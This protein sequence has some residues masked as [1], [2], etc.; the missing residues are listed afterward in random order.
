MS[1]SSDDPID[2]LVGKRVRDRR[3]KLGICQ[4]R[5]GETLGISVDQIEK[6]ETSQE[7][8]GAGMLFRIA[9]ALD[10]PVNFFFDSEQAAIAS[11]VEELDFRPTTADLPDC[12]ALNRAFCAIGDPEIRQRII[13]LVASLKDKAA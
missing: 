12:I 5:F 3:L 13:D 11:E 8:I 6:C 10:V 9:E 2:N 4:K 7:R 1:F